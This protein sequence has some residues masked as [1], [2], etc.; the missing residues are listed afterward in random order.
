MKTIRTVCA[1]LLMG[2]MASVSLQAAP[3]PAEYRAMDSE[4]ASPAADS[5]ADSAAAP[6]EASSAEQEN[7]SDEVLVVV[8]RMPEF[9]GGQAALFKFIYAEMQYPPM[10]MAQRHQGR[11]ILQFVVEKDGRM[12]DVRVARGTGYEALDAEAL[13]IV[14]KM[15][16]WRPGEQGDKPVRVMYT[17]PVYFKLEPIV[18]EPEYVGGA[19]ARLAFV[20]KTMK[21]PKDAK[22]ALQEGTV[23]LHF[24]IGADG[25]VLEPEV[26]VSSGSE[27]LDKEALRIVNAMPAWKPGTADNKPQEMSA[28]LMVT[29][30][31]PAEYVNKQMGVTVSATAEVENRPVVGSLPIPACREKVEGTVQLKVLI[32]TDGKVISVRDANSEATMVNADVLSLTRK[33][34]QKAR[35]AESPQESVGIITYT[36]TSKKK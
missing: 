18:V 3:M 9:P 6:T 11:C 23:I 16:L 17:V 13:R 22:K 31:L 2:W 30:T 32:G 10:E 25:K 29:F 8:E 19:E 20:E 7:D 14:S 15:P 4:T 35:F 26:F 5:T 33:A 36:F 34:A 24:L 1:V 28:A 12:T 27:S 21:Y